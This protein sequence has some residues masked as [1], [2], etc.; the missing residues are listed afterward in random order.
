MRRGSKNYDWSTHHPSM[1]NADASFWTTGGFFFCSIVPTGWMSK[2]SRTI[3]FSFLMRRSVFTLMMADNQETINDGPTISLTVSFF[4]KVYSISTN[5]MVLLLRTETARQQ[6]RRKGDDPLEV[7]WVW[8]GHSSASRTIC[9]GPMGTTGRWKSA[10]RTTLKER[11]KN[12]QLSRH[13]LCYR[14]INFAV[15]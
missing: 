1:R 5:D 11:V 9:V 15:S 6:S 10:A 4:Y 8:W 13:F 7:R 2:I 12:V 3:A 14:L